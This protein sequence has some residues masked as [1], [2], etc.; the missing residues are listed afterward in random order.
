MKGVKLARPLTE[1]G[2]YVRSEKQVQLEN[3]FSVG[4]NGGPGTR[5]NA[6]VQRSY[7]ISRPP[8]RLLR[9]FESLDGGRRDRSKLI[10][11]TSSF[12]FSRFISPLTAPLLK[13]LSE[14]N[15]FVLYRLKPASWVPPATQLAQS[16]PDFTSRGLLSSRTIILRYT[17]HVHIHSTNATIFVP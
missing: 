7:H 3:C 1:K 2:M 14:S 17:S 8:S 15:I 6:E 9:L 16:L 10:S 4:R 12:S 5:C 13:I 11:H